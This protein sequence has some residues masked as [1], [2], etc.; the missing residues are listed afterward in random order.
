MHR[1][2]V[3]MLLIGI[4]AAPAVAQTASQNDR[5]AKEQLATLNDAQAALKV[6]EQNGA[7][8]FATSL[9]NE[10]LAR[11]QFAQQNWTAAKSST[12]DQSRLWAIEALWASR[13]ALAKARW[14]GTNSAI[15]SLQT[16][17]RRLG[18][19]AEVNLIDEPADLALNRG[20]SSK[21]HVD[22]AQSVV[23][24]AKAAGGDQVAA[25]DLKTAQQ[26][27]ESARKILRGNA[28]S[29]TADYLAYISEMMG[30]RALY[31]ARGNAAAT[32]LPSLQ[33]QRTQL[34]Q[35]ESE[36]QAASERARRAQAEAQ[37][38]ALQQQLAQ[39]QANRQA[40]QAQ[41]DQLRGQVEANRVAIQQRIE[42]DRAAR[43][44]EEQAV[45]QAYTRYQT[46]LATGSATDIEN[47]R[48]QLEDAQIALRA[49]QSREQANV[50]SMAAE[51]DALRTQLQAA[52]DRKSMT[53]DLLAQR[54]A[55]LIQRQQLLDALRQE[56]EANLTARTQLEQQRSASLA[57]AQH[58]RAETEAQAQAMQ[59]QVQ[60]AQAAAQKASDAA[61]A[62]QQQT[63]QAQAELEKTR[64]Q[65]AQRDAEA[66]QLQVQQDLARIAAT[67]KSD[68]GLI[69]T[70][71]GIFFDTGKS[72]LKAGA[73]STLDRI[74]KQLKDESAARI[75]VEGHTDNTGGTE[76]NLAL[77]DKRAQAV[78]D[79]LV[80]A[81][82]PADHIT[83]SGKGEAEPLATNKTAAGRQQNRR[84]ELIITQ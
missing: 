49:V 37:S 42:Q 74:A 46:A 26:Y 43:T 32:Q 53:T 27:L 45:D 77:S 73:K 76:K 75:A 68:R 8:Q 18:G 71:P 79:Y 13:A 36:R 25:D 19:T 22:F 81:G 15:A 38:A 40:Q 20:G 3:A 80:S 83:A 12:R 30:R 58:R 65:L 4:L 62:A 35:A 61:K 63:A 34:A 67:R 28:N 82:I 84:V 56:R 21:Q 72:A 50:S 78:R 10:A 59:Q 44:Q 52:Q 39:E 24:A 5:I 69:V 2:V 9:Y 48:R 57:E 11:L 70:L 55:E 41:I 64:Q 60:Q 23:D 17:I 1:I 29:E 33:L 47:A 31:T 7:P 16:D 54:Q 51:I 14:I 66:H 6:A